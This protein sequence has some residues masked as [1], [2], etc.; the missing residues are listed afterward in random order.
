MQDNFHLKRN[1]S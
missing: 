1:V